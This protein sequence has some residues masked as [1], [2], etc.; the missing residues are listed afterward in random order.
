MKNSGFFIDYNNILLKIVVFLN[1]QKNKLL[2]ALTTEKHIFIQIAARFLKFEL[3]IL[4]I[5]F[6]LKYNINNLIK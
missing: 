3:S 6:F 5:F 4:Y 1:L 2:G